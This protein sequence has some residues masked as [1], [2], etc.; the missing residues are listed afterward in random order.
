MGPDDPGDLP[1]VADIDKSRIGEA[2]EIDEGLE[3]VLQV[4]GKG[5]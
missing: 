2:S 1:S 3:P 4:S 5:A